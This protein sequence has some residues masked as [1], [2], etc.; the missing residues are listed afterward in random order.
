MTPEYLSVRNLKLQNGSFITNDDVDNLNKV[1]VL[2]NVIASDIFGSGARAID[3][4]GKMIKMENVVVTVVGV[5]ES[6]TMADSAIFIPLTTAETR[7]LGVRNYSTIS[8]SAVD[9][10]IVDQTKTDIENSLKT[11]L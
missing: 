8:I 2:G 1:A 5:L 7:V 9:T 10:T 3:P 4:I 11:Y 6:N